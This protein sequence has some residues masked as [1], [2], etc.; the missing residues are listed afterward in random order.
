M[1]ILDRNGV[2]MLMG[3]LCRQKLGNNRVKSSALSALGLA[4]RFKLSHMISQLRLLAMHK[5]AKV[6][7]L[8]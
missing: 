7:F 2:L 1:Q 5:A 8:F 4:V 3:S 6:R